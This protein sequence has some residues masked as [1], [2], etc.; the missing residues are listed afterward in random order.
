[1]PQLSP[2]RTVYT[3]GQFLE[4][5]RTGV[6]RLQP[7]FQ[8]RSVWSLKAKSLL[9]DSVV[10]GLPMPIVFLRQLQDL[11]TFRSQMEVVD[12]QQRLRTLLSFI[13][14]TSLPDFDPASDA[15]VVRR[16]HNADVADRPFDQL[17]DDIKADILNY[18][19]STH[20]FPPSTGDDVVLLVFSRLNSTG[21][22]LTPQEIRNAKWFGVFKT[23]S[24]DLA[25]RHLN[26]WRS[27]QIFSDEEIAQMDEVEAVSDF[28]LTMIRGVDG[29]SQAKLNAAYRAYD[30]T[31][32]GSEEVAEKFNHVLDAIG[33]TFGDL[34]PA[35]R[36]RRQP[37]FYSLFAACTEHMYGL[38]EGYEVSRSPRP[39][40]RSARERLVRLNATIVERSLPETVQDA[41]DR[42]TTDTARRLI[43]FE[44][45]LQAL[46]LGQPR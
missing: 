12:G 34:I 5:Q 19:I 26:D 11:K 1:M 40:P 42:G 45:F 41:M 10:R 39:I 21:T 13:A 44:Y 4:W 16:I 25:L 32:E 33:D 8:R 18:E 15:F 2:T 43:R 37:L 46:D 23:L 31:L 24:Y 36:L 22:P 29:K 35:T 6:L 14:P 9:I 20:V 30:D 27:W 28:L 17:P 3:V 38:G 7:V